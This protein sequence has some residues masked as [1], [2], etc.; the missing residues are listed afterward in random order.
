ME[1]GLRV[2]GAEN[3]QVC[4][5]K[6]LQEP[7]DVILMDMQMPVMD[8][9]TATMHLRQQGLQ[10]PIIALTAHAMKGFEQD[11]IA[12]GCSG[13][14][15]KPVDIDGLIQTLAKLLGGR[16]VDQEE[17]ENVPA[18]SGDAEQ[19]HRDLAVAEPPL[20]SRLVATNPR[21]VAIVAK[22]VQRLD[23]QLEAM[24]R[25]VNERNFEELASLAHW[26]K[27]SGGTVGFDAFTEPAANLEQLAQAHSVDQ[28]EEAVLTLRQL[29]NRV[30][31]SP[32]A[33]PE[34]VVARP[35]A[36]EQPHRDPAVAEPPLVS[37]LVAANPRF[38]AIVDKFV[39]RLDEQL[40]AMERAVNERNFDELASLAHWLKGSGGTVGFDAFTEPAAN[41]EQLA[42][43][44]NVDQSQEAIFVL[45]RLADRVVISSDEKTLRA[46]RVPT[47][48][49]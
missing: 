17:P 20:V 10:T 2:E 16:R 9:R 32:E 1:V 33:A 28:L 24:E 38:G 43:T 5:E 23:E 30:V 19:S 31:V 14:L 8:G 35:A 12:I 22:F 27:G 26:L 34:S 48:V 13:Y 49:S 29:A 6:A 3:G 39:R 47:L 21:F 18:R 45:R 11:I 15:T 25:A 36:D 37:R 46:A 4:V 7:F 44:Q 40:E 41:L 42:R